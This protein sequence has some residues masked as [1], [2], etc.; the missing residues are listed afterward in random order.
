V[1]ILGCY[2]ETP[3]LCI[4]NEKV[5]LK[6]DRRTGFIRDIFCKETGI[7]HK[8]KEDSGIWPF[9]LRLGESNS[10]DLLRVEINGD[11][12]CAK[13]E[14]K[15]EIKSN[16][17]GKTLEMH[18][19]DLKTAGGNSTG[20]TLTIYITLKEG[21]D[22][23]LFK[24]KIENHGKYGITNLFSGLGGLVADESRDMENLAI[25]DWSFGTVWHNPFKV[26]KERET[27]GYPIMGSMACMDAGWM[28]L[29]GRKGG[30][31][32][33]YLN[34]QRL[35]M[36]FNVQSKGNGTGINW[37]LFNLIHY[38]AIEDWA[39]V[40][41]IYP[42]K[43]GE[44]FMTDQWILAPHA[45]DW[46]RMADI[47]RREYEETFKG[48][49]LTWDDVNESAKKIYLTSVCTVLSV[50]DKGLYNKFSDVPSIIRDFVGKS[51]INP[52]NLLVSVVGHSI[53]WPLY[54]PDFFPCCPEG[55]G[56]EACKTMVSDLRKMGVG[57]IMFFTHLH[58]NHPKANDYV[59]EADT[60]YD[61]QN[62]NWKQIGHLACLANESWQKLWKEKYVAGFNEIDASGILLDE[63]SIQWLVCTDSKHRHGTKAVNVLSAQTKGVLSIVQAFKDGFKKRN[64]LIWTEN[65][66]D[67]QT[68]FADI[69]QGW[70]DIPQGNFGRRPSKNERT[71]KYEII[72]Y[73]FPYK[74]GTVTNF[75]K[76]RDTSYVNDLLVNG[77]I[78]G[79]YW[80]FSPNSMWPKSLTPVINQFLKIR[81]Q[82][83]EINAPGFPYGFR[84]TI[85]L[86]VENSNLVA[87]A[88]RDDH[89]ITIIYYAKEDVNTS[90]I[91][92]KKSLG[93]S[94]NDQEE[95]KVA[96]KKDEASFKILK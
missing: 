46:H 38:K 47:Y 83:K 28:D 37:Q 82:L 69:W 36:F 27:F 55:G 63:G 60:G 51:G 30:I 12:R 92:N 57:A 22:Y 13:Q 50:R 95:I 33:G 35:S 42:L 84:D 5:E 40:G 81:K 56:D 10:P 3:L 49:Y 2:V 65:G 61:Y 87:R 52:E 86:T 6:L 18:Y 64:A 96:L 54:M 34:K 73:T 39:I 91:V 25:P 29:Y 90:I 89:G 11:P 7:H 45:G 77:F 88:Y 74:L 1:V 26:F 58:Y 15:Y 93:L 19:E 20:I 70:D 44:D 48:E 31:G 80:G 94:G 16:I 21:A 43:P 14:M 71:S 67:I 79:G 72:R 75:N 53:H 23:F 76:Q 68:A 32:I 17:W 9:G 8:D 24:A 85:G 78:L 4:G 59:A 66:S 41:G 62:V